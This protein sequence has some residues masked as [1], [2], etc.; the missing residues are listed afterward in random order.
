MKQAAIYARI[1]RDRTGEAAGVQRQGRECR[2]LA[3]RRRWEVVEVYIDDD[4]S[5]YSG[6]TRPAYRR[7]LADIRSGKVNAVVTFHPDRLYRRL[8]DLEELITIVE[9]RKVD[10]ATVTAGDVDLS[11]PAGRATAR[12]IGT[13][14]RYES[15]QK[16]E[17]HRSKHRELAEQGRWH[18]GGRRRFGYVVDASNKPARLLIN[19]EEADLLRAAAEAVIGGASVNSVARRWNE[20]GVRTTGGRRWTLTQ[21]RRLL[22]SPHVAGKRVHGPTGSVTDAQWPAILSPATH[23]LLS[24]RLNDPARRTYVTSGQAFG[25]RFILSG[26]VRCSLCGQGMTGRRRQGKAWA[27]F[28][29]SGAGGCGR[30]AVTGWQVDDVVMGAVYQRMGDVGAAAE[31][32]PDDEPNPEREDLLRQLT[33][34]EAR[35]AS[36][37]ADY[38]AGDI[39]AQE[40]RRAK[41]TVDDK[42]AATESRLA[43]LLPTHSTRWAD[44]IEPD[45]WHD[46]LVAAQLTPA[47]AAEAHDWV[48]SWVSEIVISP[49]RKRGTR[50]DSSRV[51]VT[52]R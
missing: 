32:T 10:V 16:G 33:D 9:T 14:A 28:C 39:T 31:A 34:L 13:M 11:T 25:R 1:S 26:L 23:E 12:I 2:A 6:K 36:I 4:I 50:F 27:Y 30:M 17:R 8:V 38:A 49:A 44:F 43:E 5:A 40:L 41:A 52:W 51:K 42:R 22:L 19:P 37:D 18:G 29:S 35:L 20:D 3:E 7:M 21:V 47:E 45:D 15:E 46:R 48:A 24:A